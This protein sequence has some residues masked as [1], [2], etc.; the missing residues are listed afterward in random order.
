MFDDYDHSAK[1]E[2]L[3]TFPDTMSLNHTANMFA[4][5][6]CPLVC[7]DLFDKWNVKVILHTQLM[8]EQESFSYTHDCLKDIDHVPANMT[9]PNDNIKIYAYSH[10]LIDGILSPLYTVDCICRPRDH[11]PITRFGI[12]N[13]DKAIYAEGMD[14]EIEL[15]NL[16]T[17]NT[18]FA[19]L[20]RA[21][22]RT[23]KVRLLRIGSSVSGK[24]TDDMK[25]KNHADR[26]G[27]VSAGE[28]E[29]CGTMPSVSK[30]VV[31]ACE[32]VNC[33]SVEVS[34]SDQPLKMNYRM[35][36]LCLLHTSTKEHMFGTAFTLSSTTVV[37]RLSL[38]LSTASYEGA[39][40]HGT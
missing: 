28:K 32:I 4:A 7:H 5:E 31:A 17:V 9:H 16:G 11:D 34:V 29:V 23:V 30:D 15:S 12:K 40:Q 1:E 24:V 36:F 26:A 27:L 6:F 8:S 19:A 10:V 22:N 14:M 35:K 18:M 25:T 13:G 37:D 20:F 2:L 3:P 39:A 33:N 38:Q 21:L